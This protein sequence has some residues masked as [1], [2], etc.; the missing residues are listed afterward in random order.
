MSGARSINSLNCGEYITW[1]QEREGTGLTICVDAAEFGIEVTSQVRCEIS[2][3]T[4]LKAWYSTEEEPKVEEPFL[5][6]SLDGRVEGA[7]NI[8]EAI[9]AETK[10]IQFDL[11]KANDI[12]WTHLVHV[13]LPAE[14]SLFLSTAEFDQLLKDE[15]PCTPGS[16]VARESLTP[17]QAHSRDRIEE[18]LAL[19]AAK[20]EELE[21][22]LASDPDGEEKLRSILQRILEM[23][24]VFEQIVQLQTLP[25]TLDR[26]FRMQDLEI[27]RT[28]CNLGDSLDYEEKEDFADDHEQAMLPTDLIRSGMGLLGENETFGQGLHLLRLAALQHNHHT[29]ALL[30]H[31][32]YTQLQHPGKAATF[33]VRRA[34]MEDCEPLTNYAVGECHDRGSPCFGPYFGAT[35]YSLQ[36][37]AQSGY[38][39]A[40]VALAQLFR[41]GCTKNAPSDVSEEMKQQHQDQRRVQG[42][43]NAAVLRGCPR[44]SCILAH[45]YQDGQC[46]FDRDEVKAHRYFARAVVCDPD[47]AQQSPFKTQ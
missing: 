22:Q 35:V 1:T 23:Q 36:R 12:E 15:I 43:L 45:F 24:R 9:H 16:D 37:A 10:F 29:A 33:L 32:I 20:R 28:G 6:L 30:L 5:S 46:G 3:H 47:L 38:T 31:R 21:R 11:K 19:L 13:P 27:K 18:N 44:A 17:A 39:P 4:H 14:D 7:V 40:M 8:R 26:F 25:A 2:D 34:K 42:W 41:T